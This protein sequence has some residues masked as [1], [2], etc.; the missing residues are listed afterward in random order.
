LSHTGSGLFSSTA[1]HAV[2]DPPMFG[3]TAALGS[4]F[5]AV[6]SDRKNRGVPKALRLT[7]IARDGCCVYCGSTTQLQCDHVVPFSRGGTTTID[8]LVA[9]CRSCNTSKRDRT[10]EEWLR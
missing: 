6:E 2:D 4:M 1:R 3:I 5:G 8:N 7:V 10:P 9:A